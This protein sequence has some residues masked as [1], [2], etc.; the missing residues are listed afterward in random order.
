[1]DREEEGDS[2]LDVEMDTHIDIALDLQHPDDLSQCR[3]CR[4]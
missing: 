2:G 4:L 1:M 3:K